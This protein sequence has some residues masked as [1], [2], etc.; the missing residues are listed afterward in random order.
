VTAPF[1]ICISASFTAEPIEPSLHLWGGQLGVKFEARFAPFGQVMQTLLDP[2]G[3]FA[4]NTHGANVV[5]VRASDLGE[6]SAE[7]A[8][9]LVEAL[10]TAGSHYKCPLIF[11]LCPS[12]PTRTEVDSFLRAE[13]EASQPI[14]LIDY[15]RLAELYPVNEVLDPH[16]DQQGAVPYTQSYF[17]ALGT[18]IARQIAALSLL[19]YKV[20]AVDCDNTLWNGI[21]GE[22]GPVGVVLDP[23]RRA[24][25]EFLLRQREAGM[26]L[27]LAS[28]NNAEDVMETFA[29]H[30]EMPLRP[31]HFA[32]MRVDWNP[33]PAN[34]TVLAKE[35]NLGIDSFVFLDDSA[36]EC[37]EMREEQPQVLTLE[38]PSDETQIPRFLNHVWAFDHPV[39]TE[40]DRRR[41]T[42]YVQAQEFGRAFAGAHSLAHFMATLGLKVRIRG[43]EE[44]DM[45]RV[46]QLTQRTN[47]FNFTTIRRTESEIRGLPET[48]ECLVVNVADRFGE[49]GLTGVVIV[50]PVTDTL[51][52]DSFLLS[53]RVLGRGVEH[54]IMAHLGTEAL[55]RG[56]P[57]VLVNVLP[58]QK[59]QPA[60]QFLESIGAEYREGGRY[61]FPSSYLAKLEWKPVAG[62]KPAVQALEPVAQHRFIP[63]ARIARELATISQ[64]ESEMSEGPVT[65]DSSFTDTERLLAEIW[66]E[67]LK[68]RSLHATDRFFELGG[69]SLLAVLLISKVRDRFGVELPIDDVYSG[70]LTLHDLATKIDALRAGAIDSDEYEAMLAEI[71]SL[72]E[73][74]VRALLGQQ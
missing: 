35:L 24:L 69:H 40:E 58:T 6:R 42:S 16:A 3:E 66:G 38:L 70:D 32:A 44:A 48:A 74:E 2:A 1:R 33:K 71:E 8:A 5:M 56:L 34:L 7:N 13:M 65:F 62:A 11:V 46:A 61:R 31:E 51:S 18:A 22:D 45:A 36:K 27:A 25:Q 50:E 39:V 10:R 29:L 20:I 55:K 54:R 14:S 53:C 9:Q 68:V 43:A 23:P 64:I 4:A 60:I 17:V 59:N 52:V 72:S 12:A 73:E 15:G 57:I 28:K 37:A 26:L 49:Y 30:P 19:P 63:Y 21:C 41:A 47:Q 67:L